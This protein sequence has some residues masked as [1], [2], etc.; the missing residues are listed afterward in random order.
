M[1]RRFDVMPVGDADPSLTRAYKV[2]AS[3]E[4][5]DRLDKFMAYM[6]WCG[7]VGHSCVIGLS[8]DGD[9]PDRP[10][11]DVPGVKVREADVLTRNGSYEQ[12]K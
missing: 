1:R 7:G 12:L 6:S 4:F 3:E 10:K 11:V 8:V 2:T 5:L 9:G